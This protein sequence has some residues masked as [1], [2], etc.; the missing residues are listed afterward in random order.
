MSD[1]ELYYLLGALG[2]LSHTVG[3]IGQRSGTIREWL[4]GN[5]PY[6]VTSAVAVVGALVIGPGDNLDYSTQVVKAYAFMAGIGAAESVRQVVKI[7]QETAKRKAAN[8]V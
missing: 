6:L 4:L 5:I 2:Y 7:P 3:K 8:E 1:H